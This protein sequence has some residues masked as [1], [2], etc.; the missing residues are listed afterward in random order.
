[1]THWKEFDCVVINDDFERALGDLAAIV[2][3]S[4]EDLSRN[5]AEVVAL[6]KSLLETR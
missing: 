2:K 3:G 5:R 4:G 6:A 1:M